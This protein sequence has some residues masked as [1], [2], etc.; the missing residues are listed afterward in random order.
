MRRASIALAAALSSLAAPARAAD[1]D[2]FVA[3]EVL[4]VVE[5]K[6]ALPADATAAVWSRL[7]AA[8]VLVAPQ[9]TIRLND[10]AVNEK[11]A[12]LPLREVTVRAA[13]NGAS[14]ALVLE[15]ADDSED[16]AR[17][18]ETMVFGDS[19]A[20]QF[21]LRFGAGQRLP[22]IGMGDDAMPVVLYHQRAM[23]DGVRTREAVAAG[24]GSG[25]RA[26]LGGLPPALRYDA[27]ARRWRAVFVRPLA[28]PDHDLKKGLIPFAVAVWDGQKH[29]RGGNKALSP[30][31]FLRIARLPLEPAYLAEVSWGYAASDL[32]DPA[33]GKLVAESVCIACHHLPGKAFA[34]PGM[35]PDLSRLGAVASPAYI[36]QSIVEPSAILVP[37]PNVNQHYARAGAADKNGAFPNNEQFIWF[38]RDPAGNKVSRMP[39]FNALPKEDVLGLVAFLKTLGGRPEGAEAKK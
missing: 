7:P 15:W 34:L 9:S 25:T 28:T 1:G 23:E 18:D 37:N 11:L 16:R 20:L 14:L 12:G 29:E 38:M 21:P 10:R 31:K 6:E 30:W 24:F 4:S 39:P 2:A 22:Y 19:V 33:R 13:E 35:A 5:V 27:A 26:N 8:A 32:G 3:G 17:S 36:K